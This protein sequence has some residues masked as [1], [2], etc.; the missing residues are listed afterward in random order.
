M[1]VFSRLEPASLLKKLTYVSV[2]YILNIDEQT[3]Y[4]KG[5]SVMLKN[6]AARRQEHETIRNHVGFYD[7]THQLVEVKG[8]DALTFLD[9]IYVNKIAATKPGRAQYTTMLNEDGKIIDDVIVFRCQ[10]LN[11]V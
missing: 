7:F 4:L 11:L 9:R 10:V 3:D 8:P 5:E 1:P 2:Y 6:D